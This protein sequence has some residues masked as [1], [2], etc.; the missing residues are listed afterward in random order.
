MKRI[1][2]ILA[3]AVSL[4]AFSQSTVKL[5]DTTFAFTANY[6][7]EGITQSDYSEDKYKAEIQ[8]DKLVVVFEN[9]ESAGSLKGYLFLIKTLNKEKFNETGHVGRTGVGLILQGKA[10]T[11]TDRSSSGSYAD[12]EFTLAFGTEEKKNAFAEK[13]SKVK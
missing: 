9:D 1:I 2:F 8:G 11:Y 10:I 13:I 7:Y 3:L 4:N 6:H 5:Q 12:E